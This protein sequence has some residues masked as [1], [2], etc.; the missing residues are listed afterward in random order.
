MSK[1]I[2]RP[3]YDTKTRILNF[4]IYP[5]ITGRVFFDIEN[6]VIYTDV[7]GSRAAKT[8]LSSIQV[9]DGSIQEFYEKGAKGFENQIL[10]GKAPNGFRLYYV[11]DEAQVHNLT[12]TAESISSLSEKGVTETATFYYAGN[13]EPNKTYTSDAFRIAVVKY[14]NLFYY[15][16]VTNSSTTFISSDWIKFSAQFESVA[17]GLLLAENALITRG[18]VMGS[19]AGVDRGWIRNEGATGSTIPEIKTR[20]KDGNTTG[21]VLDG[22]D[23]SVTANKGSFGPLDLGFLGQEFTAS[24]TPNFSSITFTGGDTGVLVL[25][26]PQTFNLNEDLSLSSVTILATL[27]TQNVAPGPEGGY[28]IELLRNSQIQ[29][30]VRAGISGFIGSGILNQT[31]N[32]VGVVANSIRITPYGRRASTSTTSISFDMP[33]SLSYIANKVI[34][35]L[36]YTK[37]YD[38]GF[39]LTDEILSK[40]LSVDSFLHT[41]I[42]TTPSNFTTGPFPVDAMNGFLVMNQTA[43]ILLQFP[44]DTFPVG[45]EM[46]VMRRNGSVTITASNQNTLLPTSNVTVPLNGVITLKQIESRV[47]V[48]Y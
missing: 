36:G 32:T 20:I 10:V 25:G 26:T 29:L 42:T 37:F 41:K 40:T 15:A 2:V 33:R 21:F 48:A 43:G 46:R 45:S 47:W 3:I 13:W 1:E 24:F 5:Y 11:D 38:S 22:A 31:L 14:E 19:D 34:F 35:D 9:F 8:D 7:D 30:S 17:T 4:N 6:Q 44:I 28:F 12:F 39:L 18:L 27:T 16:K 23:G